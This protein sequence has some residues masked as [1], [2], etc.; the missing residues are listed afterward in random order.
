MIMSD[1]LRVLIDQKE[2]L[3]GIDTSLWVSRR[4]ESLFNLKSNRAQ[5]VIG[6]RR[7]GKSTICKK[8]LLESGVKFAYVNFDDE[9]LVYLTIADMN[10]VMQTLYR[11][12]GLFDYLLLDEIQNIDGWHLF[13]NR[14]MREGVK[15]VLTG[16]N[17]NLLSGELATHLTGRYNQISLYPFSFYDYCVAKGVDVK[18]MSTKSIALRQRALD[19]YLLCG[20]FPEIIYG[21]DKRGYVKSL[22]SAIIQKDICRRYSVN[23]KQTIWEIANNLIDKN[24]QEVSYSVLQRQFEVGSVHT[25][26]NYVSYLNE[27]FLLRIVSK[28][29]NKSIDRLLAKKSYVTDLAFISDREDVVASQNLG[30]RLENAVLLELFRRIDIEYQQVYYLKKTNDFEV[31][32]VVYE[33]SKVLELI[34]VTYVLNKENVKLYKREVGGLVKGAKL[35]RCVNLTIICLEGEGGQ[36]EEDGVK[37]NVV[38]A[39]DWFCEN[40]NYKG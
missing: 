40:K 37:I 9:R 5:V 25:V 6:V 22:L 14:I 30:W 17:A 32:F 7:C 29:S 16:S 13:V 4:E 38:K 11:V 18:S 36:I 21:D 12:Y 33:S 15:V 39:S 34:Q 27:A 35:T 8:V 26:K 2:E 28:F 20:G 1:L 23:H 19:E 3:N 24:C 31:D 10:D